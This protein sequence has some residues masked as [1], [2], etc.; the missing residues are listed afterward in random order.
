RAIANVLQQSFHKASP[1]N[2]VSRVPD[3]ADVAEGPERRPACLDRRHP[4]LDVGLRLQLDVQAH[5]L[6]DVAEDR[7][8][9]E[10]RAQ[11]CRKNVEPLHLRTP[12][13]WPASPW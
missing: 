9:P 4:A 11:A 12:F 7:L 3:D 1:S 2:L 5:L 8:A 6:V 10:Q 13:T